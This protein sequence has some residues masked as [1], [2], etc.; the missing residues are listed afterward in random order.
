MGG[1][2]PETKV[3]KWWRDQAFGWQHPGDSKILVSGHYHHYIHKTDPRSWFQVPS[4]DESTWF[5]HQ[6]GKSTQQGLFTM[7]IEDTERGYSNA[8]VV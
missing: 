5:K 2:T 1:G 7:V 8:E 4:L 3:M 6:T